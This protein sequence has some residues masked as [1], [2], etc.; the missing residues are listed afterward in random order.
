MESYDVVVV[1]AGPAGSTA[2]YH[3]RGL[4]T[5]II[6]RYEFP[7]R[8]ACGGGLMSVRDWSFEFENF[9][10]IQD[11]ITS[12]YSHDTLRMYWNRTFTLA[13]K[14]KHLFDQVD[15]KEFDNLLLEVALEK[16]N[17]SFRKFFLA[18]IRRGTYKGKSGYFLSDGTEE[19]FTTLIIGADGTFSRVS[20]F[21]GNED[22][23]RHHYGV[24]LEYDIVCE[25][26]TQDVFVSA[27]YGGEIGYSWIFPTRKGYYVGIG[28]VREPRKSIQTYLNDYVRWSV[29]QGWIPKDYRIAHTLGAC[30]P[31]KVVKRYCSHG[32]L[33]C[34]DAM[35]VVKVL[36]G[37]GIYFAMK[38]G[39]LA[40]ETVSESVENIHVR[41]RKKIQPVIREVFLTP[42]IPARVLTI[43]FWTAFFM[44]GKLVDKLNMR[45]YHFLFN[46]F[47]R[48]TLHRQISVSSY[49]ADE[50][51]EWKSE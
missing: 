11:K 33:L 39:K 31:L 35:G 29:E 1:G 47:M 12:A 2:A 17:V 44:L 51:I 18:T 28:I 42:Y 22:R 14:F 43:W 20:K 8:K 34:G 23:K 46:F 13:R 7:R 6:D 27:G 10:K 15:R 24:C 5:L 3:I 30:I 49:Y 38:S 21:L 32:V 48:M 41:Y 36:T 40:G 37:E 9:A 50:K 4:K 25:K 26:K 16:E 19:I 45:P